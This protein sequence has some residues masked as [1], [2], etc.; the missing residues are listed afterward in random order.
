MAGCEP[1]DAY[2]YGDGRPLNDI[3]E[4]PDAPWSD[5]VMTEGMG[6]FSVIV[7][8]RMFRKGR[9]KYVFNGAD[10]DQFFDM[11]TD[12]HEMHNLIKNPAYKDTIHS[13]KDSCAD[14]MQ[15]HNDPIRDAFCKVNHLKE[16]ETLYKNIGANQ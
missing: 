13:V 11:E 15:E 3:L 5:E 10:K 1:T 8:Q 12:P 4:N 14:W 6:A 16:W 9:Y 7:T 2:G